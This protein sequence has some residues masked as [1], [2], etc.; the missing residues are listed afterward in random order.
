MQKTD[1]V[2]VGQGIAGSM[3]AYMLH[4]QNIPFIVIDPGYKNTSSRVAAGMFSPISGKRKTI[5]PLVPE[6]IA[7]AVETYREIEQLTGS[8][9]LN[10]GNVY[11]I[12][13]AVDDRNELKA[14]STL[15]GFEKYFI[16]EPLPLPN[17]K[18]EAGACEFT[19]SGWVNCGLLITAFAKWISQND[20]LIRKRF[21]YTDLQIG[22][23]MMKYGDLEFNNI[24]FCEGYE[25]AKNPFFCDENIIPCKGD[26]LTI[27]YDGLSTDRIVKKNSIYL[28]DTGN[29][30]FRTGSTYQWNNDDEK[31]DELGRRLITKQLDELL[32]NG[33]TITEHR[34]AIRPTTKSREVIAKKHP[35]HR[36]MFMLNG[37]G[38]KGVLQGPWF[39]RYLVNN[40]LN[41]CR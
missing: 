40:I 11:H 4:L 34:A 9:F 38:T 25:A 21:L 41:T 30:T 19:S 14:K 6:Q 22:D 17:L 20:L 29:Q 1:T 15:P 37:L 35:V 33:Y 39:A 2:V 24:I 26:M 8:N 23:G 36:R 7:F 28:I 13:N 10:T 3:I 16:A 27:K 32:Q 5:L 12:Y 31:P 18:A